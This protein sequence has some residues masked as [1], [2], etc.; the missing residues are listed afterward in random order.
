[1]ADNRTGSRLSLAD[2]LRSGE[3]VV[4]GWSTLA[5][6][7]LSELMARAGYK[8]VTFD[9]QHGLHDIA[10]VRD[11][12]GAAI[13]GGAHPVVR[14]PV[15]EFA[16]ASRVLD[17]GAEAVIMPMVNSVDDALALV[18][19]TKY[20]P[21]GA[22]S[23]APHHAARLLSYA[24]DGYTAASNTQTLAF[25]MVET[26]AALAALDDICE[27][28]GLDGIFVGPSDLSFTLS[29]GAGVDP[30][31]KVA[32]DAIADIAGRVT[33]KGKIAAIYCSNSAHAKAAIGMGY[34]FL[35]LGADAGFISSGAAETLAS[36]DR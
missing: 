30:T 23:W 28:E 7:V 2:R 36:L 15:D 20:P 1:M 25:A 22:R 21:L 19:A 33:A 5:V 29:E 17:F 3:T 34:R 14:T 18:G 10:S 9:M 27:V 31:G 32:M 12:V 11:A 24:A 6:P 13:I 35:A 8:A 26:P 16:T 4:T